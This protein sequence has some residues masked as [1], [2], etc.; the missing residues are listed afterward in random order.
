MKIILFSKSAWPSAEG[1]LDT[2]SDQI[3]SLTGNLA[4]L[5]DLLKSQRP[6]VVFISQFDQTEELLSGIDALCKAHPAVAVVPIFVKPDSEFLIKLMRLGVREVLSSTAAPAL[7]EAISRTN[8]R[9]TSIHSPAGHQRSRSMVFMSAKGGDGGSCVAANFAAA[10]ARDKQARVLLIDLSI[11]FGDV[12]MYITSEPAAHD[13]AD[14]SDEIDRLDGALM[15]SMVQHVKENL[16]IIPTPPSFEKIIHITPEHIKKLIEIAGNQYD[17]LIIDLGTGID[18][19]TLQALDR[20]DELVVVATMTVPS[21]RRTSQILRLWE[22]L[23]HSAAK[24]SV[25]VNKSSGKSD[26]QI[27][28]FEKAMAKKVRWVLPAEKEGVDE[29]LLKGSPVIDLHPK[30]PFSKRILEWAQDWGGGN[31]TGEKS[32]WHRFGIK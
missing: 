15:Q 22:S 31:F 11:P 24:V 19:I 7:R 4:N 14:F 23:G 3:V 5:P 32:I 28:E 20:T 18:P 21:V 13:L 10:L 27:A 29:S 6:D 16:D 26:I 25:V 30:S 12:E 8:D 2:T 9:L 1:G 17:F